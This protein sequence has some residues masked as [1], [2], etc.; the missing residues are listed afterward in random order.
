LANQKEKNITED[1]LEGIIFDKDGEINS[2]KGSVYKKFIGKN[3]LNLLTKDKDEDD[4]YKK[5]NKNLNYNVKLSGKDIVI[6]NDEI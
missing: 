4:N 5:E 3:T 2:T 6:I 1:I